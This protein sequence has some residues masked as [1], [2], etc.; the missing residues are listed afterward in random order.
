MK[1]FEV[2]VQQVINRKV[3]VDAAH[4]SDA[5]KLA[6]AL[7]IGGGGVEVNGHV[8]AYDVTP[9][10]QKYRVKIYRIFEEVVEVEAA[11]EAEAD[12]EAVRRPTCLTEIGKLSH[13][14]TAVEKIS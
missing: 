2:K 7:V 10:T 4:S 14:K 5:Q 11:S 6:E 8:H 9:F 3:V 12:S 1:K 13:T